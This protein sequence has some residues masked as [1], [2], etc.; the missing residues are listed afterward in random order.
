MGRDFGGGG[1]SRANP[2]GSGRSARG[3]RPDFRVDVRD[4]K[5]GR[6]S[7]NRGPGI[8]SL[9]RTAPLLDPNGADLP[10]AFQTARPLGVDLGNVKDP[11]SQWDHNYA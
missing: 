8:R 11:Q 9:G 5:H 7:G 4:A 6:C 1:K 10:A 2:A 3:H